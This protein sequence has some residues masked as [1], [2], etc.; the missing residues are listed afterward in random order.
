MNKKIWIYDTTLRDGTQAH[1]ITLSSADKIRIAQKLDRLGIDYI[2]GGWPG[3]NETD[4][5]F[6]KKIQK[7]NLAHARVAAFGSTHGIKTTA[8]KD[9]NLAALVAA[10]PDVVTIFGKSW[11][12]H[13]HEALRTT[14]EH[15]ITIIHNSI[16]FLKK[17]FAETFYDAEHFFDG[18]KA[19][20]DY[21]LET[22][23]A[24]ATA[25]ADVLVLCDT[26]GG[27]LPHE[28]Y[29]IVCEVGK[30]LPEV[31]LGIHAHNDCETAVANTLEAVRAGA[32][33]VQGTINGYG[34][35]CGNAN[36]CSIIPSLELKT[37]QKHVCLPAGN[38]AQ[39]TSVSNYV[40]ETCNLRPY[41][42]QPYVGSAAFA[43]KGGVH[44][45]AVM[46]NA[47]T[48]E[49][50]PP[51]TVGNRQ[52]VLLSDLAGRSN[53]QF[54]AKKFGYELDKNDS[55]VMDLLTEL[56][57]RENMGYEYTSAE[58]SF[59]L[60][61][62]KTMGW[63]KQYFQL[64]NF[65]VMDALRQNGETFIEATVM[66]KVGGKVE[67]TAASG[68]GQVNSLD[69]A[70]RKALYPFYPNLK[71]MYLEDFKVRVL[72]GATRDTGGTASNVRVLI[73]SADK[74]GRWSTVGVSYDVIHA[75][76][77]ALVD[78]I[79]YKLFKDDPKK[80]PVEAVKKR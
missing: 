59:E 54:M 28:V 7:I 36:L 56:K 6:F 71:D 32:V 53:I 13:V 41:L 66:L 73:D 37:A 80:W 50:I 48:Y 52:Q 12:L 18:F 38:L 35:R 64:I 10:K 45:S 42:R 75:S 55:A 4:R 14:K 11:D 70:L 68:Q 16:L 34:E 47:S 58:A 15:N 30:K 72:S 33:H 26:N 40:N 23:K 5:D 21:A 51:E 24:A 67:H 77:E 2:E 20:R 65:S 1:D 46:R 17:H 9:K 69:S 78:S 25:G 3:S 19:N 29:N 62:F 8:E 44:V 22:L 79:N 43:H 49:H 61:F 31:N 60:M 76:W 57:E 39:L 63:S 27:C 74:T